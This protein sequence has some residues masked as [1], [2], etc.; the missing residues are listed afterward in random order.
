[1]A[2]IEHVFLQIML[3]LVNGFFF[4]AIIDSLARNAQ[5]SIAKS[6][7]GS[8]GAILLLSVAYAANIGGMAVVTGTPPNLVAFKTLDPAVTFPAWMGFARK[9]SHLLFDLFLIVHFQ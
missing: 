7:Q 3:F 4:T 6:F 9:L 5:G 2:H 1:M 8:S